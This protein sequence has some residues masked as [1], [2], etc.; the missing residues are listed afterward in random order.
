V[1]HTVPSASRTDTLTRTIWAWLA[2]TR[3]QERGIRFLLAAARQLDAAYR[4]YQRVK[5]DY[6]DVARVPP[7]RFPD[8][9]LF[10]QTIADV[11]S[12]ILTLHR[13]VHM[14]RRAPVVFQPQRSVPIAIEDRYDTL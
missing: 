6:S 12:T 13:V 7:G 10:R 1:A 9:E 5:A 11:E 2:V 4:S 8:P 14:A 3:P